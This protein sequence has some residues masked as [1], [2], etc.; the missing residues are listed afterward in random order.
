MRLCFSFLLISAVWG[1]GYL[2]PPAVET[3]RLREG[4]PRLSFRAETG[5]GPGR[6]F[7][8][9]RSLYA[10]D[11]EF[12]KI[13]AG[14]VARVGSTK[15]PAEAAAVWVV[16]GDEGAAGRAVKLLLEEPI[17]KT[18]SGSYSRV[19]SFALAWDWLYGHEALKE[20]RERAAE[21]IIERLD[22]EL[23]WLDEGSMA[24]WHGRNQAANGAIVAALA[25][26]DRPGSERRLAR[27]AAHYYQTLRALQYSE[28]WPEGPSYW[29]HNR[30]AP[31]ALAADCYLTAT[32]QEQLGGIGIRG[33]MAS[34][35]AWTLYQFGPNRVFEPYGDAAGS[36]RLGETGWW[37]A[38]ADYFARLSRDESLRAGG[39]WFRRLSP[40][41]YGK[42]QLQWW[43]ALAYEGRWQGAPEEW[44]RR[45]LPATRMFGKGSMGVAF[46][47]GAWGD[48]DELFASFKAGDLLAH[49]DHYDVGHFSIQY[50]GLLAPLTGIYGDKGGYTGT[51]RLGYAIQTVASNSLLILAPGETSA[52]LRAQKGEP[53]VALSGGQRVIR[54][55]GFDCLSVEDFEAQRDAGPH[56]RRARI[57]AFESVPGR[58]DYVAADL[59]PAYNSTVWAEAGAVAKVSLVTRDFVYLRAERVFV[60]YDRVETTDAGYLPKFLLHSLSKPVSGGERLLAGESVENGIVETLERRFT[61]G[62]GRGE[63]TVTSLL[64]REARTLKIGGRDYYAYV[65]ADGDEKDGF[66]GVKLEA[67][68]AT[69]PRETKQ[70][71]LWRM[72]IEPRGAG[73]SHR[74]LTVLI[75]R[76]K[77]EGGALPEVRLVEGGPGADAVKVGGKVLVFE[78]KAGGT[79]KLQQ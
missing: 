8:S 50:G 34:I 21:R 31:F 24:L 67:G 2:P 46:F 69:V 9:V 56:L 52:G 36:L 60:V 13:F 29:I 33:L 7:A 71:G 58:Y 28:G 75:P 19:W 12:R 55:T 66:D 70:L 35:G 6:S 63:L 78:R 40:T 65:E 47:R 73:T 42:G 45:H 23:A 53:W 18:G 32:G 51:Y 77:S 30:A 5:P 4:H 1:Q 57:T 72:E 10:S 25:V 39:E 22:T 37:E 26:G 16:T 27:A 44:L 62:H 74:F 79:M 20:G 14:A 49:H 11:A 68:D 48:P 43:S 59:T 3:V 54:P 61:S 64:P 41:P 17:S 15:D 76:L 38:T